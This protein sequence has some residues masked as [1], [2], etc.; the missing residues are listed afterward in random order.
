MKTSCQSALHEINI[1]VTFWTACVQVERASRRLRAGRLGRGGPRARRQSCLDGNYVSRTKS[2]I[3]QFLRSF[4]TTAPASARRA[5]AAVRLAR[6]GFYYTV[7]RIAFTYLWKE[8]LKLCVIRFKVELL[9]IHLVIYCP[10]SSPEK[11][12]RQPQESI[13]LR[14]KR[15]RKDR[16]SPQDVFETILPTPSMLGVDVK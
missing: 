8:F 10:A 5:S 6:K 7:R 12:R 2:I 1:S 11:D 16:R 13:D 9:V 14:S 3:H 15:K 4:I